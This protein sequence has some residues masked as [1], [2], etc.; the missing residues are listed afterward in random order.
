MERRLLLGG[1]AIARG[2]IE[3][4]IS[5]ATS[6]PGTPAT[7]ILEYIALYS[8]VPCEWSVNEKVALEVAYGVT[9]T[10]KR[11]LC[12][13]KHVGLN[14]AADPLMTISYLGVKGGLVIA[15]GDDPGAYS[16]QNEQDTRFYAYFAKVP[17]L[18]PSDNEEA[19]KLT[20][21]GFQISEELGLPVIL[22][23]YTRLLHCLA[24][25][26]FE[27]PEKEKSLNLEKDF[28]HFLPLPKN[29]KTLHKELNEKQKK[30]EKIYERLELNKIFDGKGELGIVACGITY[31]Y[32]KEVFPDAPIYKIVA[33]P[34]NEE[35]IKHFVIPFS[36]VLVLEEGYPLVERI[37]KIYHPNV[38]GRLSGHLPMEGEL[39]IEEVWK[40]REK[41]EGKKDN[42]EKKDLFPFPR[43]P[44]L[45][46]GCPHAAF[47]EVLKEVNPDFVTGDI[48]CYTLGANPP[49]EIIHSCLCMGGSISKASALS[50]M[51]VKKV[52][53]VIG[54]STFLHT[55][56]PA[57]INAVYNRSNIVV[58]ILDNS[59][60]AMTGH[61]PT[62][63]TGLTA[64]G[65]PTKKVDIAEICRACKVDSVVEVNPFK[66][67]ELKKLLLEKIGSEGVH[68]II[69]KAP[70]VFAK[71]AL[72]KL[73]TLRHKT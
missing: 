70:C 66:R 45:C 63:E 73:E 12:S 3:A 53:A 2:A 40:L 38:I 19:R 41:L 44:F 58:C 55:G 25:V 24:P 56:I 1:Y 31:L 42:K 5:Y 51:G 16:S 21:L 14:V 46:K 71:K 28:L 62:P 57:L 37:V 35:K 15:V 9:M 11:A 17:C 32:A 43:P 10:G 23:S 60:V 48:G 54:D 72:S 7:Q 27:E 61:Q 26:T 47:F 34:V 65:E 4:G 36:R 64:K 49:L 33:Y 6:Y 59:V 20:K 68:I 39:G 8:D 69:S 30:I 67:E 52:V 22:R 50:L 29:V 18:E 13:M